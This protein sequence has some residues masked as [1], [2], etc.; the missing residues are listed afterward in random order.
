MTAIDTMWTCNNCHAAWGD[1]VTPSVCPTCGTGV[2]P[3]AEDV[4]RAANERLREAL[5][6]YANPANYQSSIGHTKPFLLNG[7]MRTDSFYC[8]PPIGSD[9]GDKAR[10]ALSIKSRTL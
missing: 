6:F 8:S 7:R 9:K 4:L 1:G 2:Q 3:N 5:V 10:A